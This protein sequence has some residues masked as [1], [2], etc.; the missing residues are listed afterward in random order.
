MGDLEAEPGPVGRDPHGD[1]AG[2]ASRLYRNGRLTQPFDSPFEPQLLGVVLDLEEID[3]AHGRALDRVRELRH[4]QEDLARGEQLGVEG[5]AQLTAAAAHVHPELARQS[6]ELRLGSFGALGLERRGR[7]VGRRPHDRERHRERGDDEGGQHDDPAA[8]KEHGEHLPQGDLVVR[9]PPGRSRPARRVRRLA[10]C[11]R[12]FLETVPPLTFPN[13][14]DSARSIAPARHGSNPDPSGGFTGSPLTPVGTGRATN[15][16]I[17]QVCPVRHI[18]G[19]AQAV[20]LTLTL[21]LVALPA[22]ASAQA[23]QSTFTDEARRLSAEPAIVEAMRIAEEIDDWAL[24][25]LIE[26]TEIPAPPFMEDERG[27]RFGELLVELGADSVWTDAEGNVIGLRKGRSGARRIGFGGHLDTVFPEGTDVTVRQVADTL[28]APGVGDDTRGL[29]VVLS[30]LRALEEAGIET[31][32]DVLF[33]GVVGEEGLGDL[34]GMKYLYSDDGEW[35]DAWIEVDGGGISGIVSMGLGSVRYR[36]TFHGPGGHSWGAFGLAHP[37]HA[38]ARG[39]RTFQD[40]ADTLTRSG[41]R[42]SYSVGRLG[43]GTS[44]N[45]IPFEAWAEVD[46]R[47]ESPENLLRIEAAFVASMEQALE[48]ENALRR[49]GPALTLD[50]AKI[51]DRP[52]GEMDPAAPLVQ[53][54]MAVTHLFDVEPSLSRGS[55]NSNVPIALGV[56]AVTIGR[57]GIGGNNHAPDEFWVNRDAYLAVQRALLI[58]LA[59]AGVGTP[60]S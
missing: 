38:L 13:V 39:I 47:S 31:E 11:H 37:S 15:H 58:V 45:S 24:D 20:L 9:D 14:S 46:M 8:A 57:G 32:D 50:L 59:E 27:E 40:V 52:S 4:A 33:V 12:A 49:D 25:L 21:A 5:R 60:I 56:P 28:F 23:V 17:R 10:T 44:V 6:E 2:L 22:H 3:E 7:R 26:L 36:P 34:R 29:V 18:L 41:P 51:G 42:T 30:V 19:S 16:P 54:A 55:T 35:P 43:G 48:E 53:R 1:D